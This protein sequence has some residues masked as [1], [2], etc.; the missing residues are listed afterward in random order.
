ML[1][2]M[3]EDGYAAKIFAKT[4]KRGIPVMALTTTIIGALTFMT[5]VFGTRIYLF[6]VAASGLTGF[7]AWLGIATALSFPGRALKCKVINCQ[8]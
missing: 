7:I 1:W 4:N 2:S 6:L 5:S 3:A 8:N